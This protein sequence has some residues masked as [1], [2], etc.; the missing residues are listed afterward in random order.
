MVF[1][2][3]VSCASSAGA[4]GKYNQVEVKSQQAIQVEEDE[5]DEED[6]EE[7][8][9]EKNTDNKNKASVAPKNNNETKV[10]PTAKQHKQGLEAKDEEEEDDNEDQPQDEGQLSGFIN[11]EIR[12][13]WQ[14]KLNGDSQTELFANISTL[15]NLQ[16]TLHLKLG[17]ES[18]LETEGRG[19][20]FAFESPSLF[21]NTMTISYAEELGGIGLGK[22][23]LLN[24]DNLVDPIWNRQFNLFDAYPSADLDLRDVI[25]LR[26]WLNLGSFMEVDHYLYGGVFF[27]DDTPLGR[28]IFTQR[29]PLLSDVSGLAYNGKLYNWMVNLHGDELPY[30]PNWEYAIGA[31]SQSPGLSDQNRELSIFSG[32]YGDYEL[33]NDID[34]YPMAEVL[35]RDGADGQDHSAISALVSLSFEDGPWI[36]GT[37][38]S[39]RHLVDHANNDDIT[40]DNEAQIFASYYFDSGA[41]IDFGYQ[42][43]SED[44][45][46][47]N[48]VSFAIG[49]PFEFTTNLYG[50]VDAAKKGFQRKSIKRIIRQSR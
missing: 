28:S 31:V 8:D 10:A 3:A 45:D 21:L 18:T 4:V 44:G 38:Y 1:I 47:Q 39:H 48:A 5:G 40:D 6:Q 16:I 11:P 32:I 14:G 22:Y 35:Y 2:L 37:S 7:G 36:Y 27:R 33:G 26:A 29:A 24:E 17:F 13:D 50:K 25:G 15:I 9:D 30:A 19:K 49:I 43:L 20:Y 46:A 23:N 42:F 34:F 12:H 41:Y